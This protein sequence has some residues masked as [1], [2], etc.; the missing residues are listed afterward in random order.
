MSTDRVNGSTFIVCLNFVIEMF[1][2]QLGDP[3]CTEE[4]YKEYFPK[5]SK[6]ILD[7]FSQF[8]I[9]LIAIVAIKILNISANKKG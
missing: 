9:W 4:L 7:N 3:K 1:L 5:I 8:L 6:V 2:K